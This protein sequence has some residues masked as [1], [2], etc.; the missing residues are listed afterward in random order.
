MND[1]KTGQNDGIIGFIAILAIV[2]GSLWFFGGFGPLLGVFTGVAKWLLT[3]IAASLISS[4]L[5]TLFLLISA[6]FVFI[7]GKSYLSRKKS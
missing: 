7:V 4:I 3:T 5:T 1:E 6:I 2:V